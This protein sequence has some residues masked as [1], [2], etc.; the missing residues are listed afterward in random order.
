[1]PKID[2]VIPV[3]EQ[4]KQLLRCL[5]SLKKQ[6]L[7]DFSIII[8]NDGSNDG[9]SDIL[10]KLKDHAFWKNRIEIIEQPNRGA[11]AARN[12]G[13]QRVKAP[14][15][16]F[17]DADV[18]LRTDC[19][20]KML[21]V[22]QLHKNSSYVYSNFKY[23]LKTFNLRPFK[24][25]NLKAQPQIHTTALMRSADFPGFDENLKR[26]QDWDLWLTML[27]NNHYGKFIDEVLFTVKPGG[28]MSRWLPSWLYKLKFLP[29]V[30]KY[31]QAKKTIVEKHNL[32]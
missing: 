7:Q 29:S 2:I 31:N 26:F 30:K 24:Q 13:F 25:L 1:M 16:L 23:G 11:A 14:F 21:R 12:S 19:L 20:D 4:G 17:C 28:T 3:F 6:S 5:D 15:V 8:V 10:K 9:T 32:N 18:T 22:L 27:K